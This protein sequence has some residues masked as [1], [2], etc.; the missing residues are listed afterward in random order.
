MQHWREHIKGNKGVGIRQDLCSS[1]LTGSERKCEGL[2]RKKSPLGF[3][4]GRGGWGGGRVYAQFSM[5]WVGT[6]QLQT[7]RSSLDE[8]MPSFSTL[9]PG[10]HWWHLNLKHTHHPVCGRGNWEKT[11]GKSPA[12]IFRMTSRCGHRCKS[13][14]IWGSPA[15]MCRE[16]LAV[17]TLIPGTHVPGMTTGQLPSVGRRASEQFASMEAA[18]CQ[19]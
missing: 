1:R 3:V 9:H 7:P 18:F 13:A 10:G 16:T 12:R 6:G 2:D 5:Q 14:P 8:G 4:C 11:Q 19:H 15:G 17:P